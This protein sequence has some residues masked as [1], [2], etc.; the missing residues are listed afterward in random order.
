MFKIS[1]EGIRILAP[2]LIDLFCLFTVVQILN[3]YV[4][5]FSNKLKYSFHWFLLVTGF[6]DLAH[7]VKCHFSLTGYA[8]VKVI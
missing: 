7:L 5:K 2:W 6:P 8:D 4:L 1:R 3:C